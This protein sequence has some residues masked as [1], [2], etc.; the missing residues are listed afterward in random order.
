MGDGV[1]ALR[2]EAYLAVTQEMAS[3]LTDFMDRRSSL[4]LFSPDS[5]LA[6][7]E[8]AAGVMGSLLGWDA[9][10]QTAQVESY[11]ALAGEH[12]VPPD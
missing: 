4:L 6:G 1:P 10:E 12:R 8:A 2:G 11:R 5:G 7:A 9:V 3:T